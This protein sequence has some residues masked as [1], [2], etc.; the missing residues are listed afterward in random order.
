MV[1]GLVLSSFGYCL[2]AFWAVIPARASVGYIVNCCDNPSTVGVYATSNDQQTAEWNVG[3]NAVAA[4]FSPDGKTAYIANQGTNGTPGVPGSITVVDVYSGATVA[5]IQVGYS[6]EWMVLSKDG[7]RLY[8]DSYDAAYY[9]HVVAIDTATNTVSQAVE[10]PGLQ[11]GPMALTPDG[12]TLYTASGYGGP[13]GVLAIDTGSLSVIT[14]VSINTVFGLAITPDGKYLYAS[15]FGSP[16]GVDVAVIDTSTNAVVTTI[17]L[18]ATSLGASVQI[19][20]DGSMVWVS[21][22]SFITVI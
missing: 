19:S 20:P 11:G 7:S 6:L 21:E 9:G 14:T 5:T 13:V 17:P 4:V 3:T 22:S 8:V 15:A 18:S 16:T 2:V 1:R 12:S 10:F